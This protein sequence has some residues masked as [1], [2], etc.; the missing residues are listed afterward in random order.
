MINQRIS[1]VADSC[2]I[3]EVGDLIKIKPILGPNI[4]TEDYY[5]IIDI[6][7]DR[8]KALFNGK[9]VTFSGMS[10]KADGLVISKAV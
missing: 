6:N 9:L 8:W 10:K 4:N 2:N 1:R 3:V 5:L 7:D